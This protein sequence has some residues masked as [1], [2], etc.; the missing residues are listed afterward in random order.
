MNFFFSSYRVQDIC[1]SYLELGLF[2]TL[3]HPCTE[4]NGRVKYGRRAAFESVQFG[5]LDLERQTT[6]NLARSV[7]LCDVGAVADSYGAPF[8]CR[9]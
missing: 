8:M 9:T 1:S 5:R 2:Q 6:L 3:L 7:A 4:T